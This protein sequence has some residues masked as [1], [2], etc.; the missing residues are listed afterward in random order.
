MKEKTPVHASRALQ[1]GGQTGSALGLPY[2]PAQAAAGPLN[3]RSSHRA[4]LKLTSFM[5]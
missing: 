2:S 4:L 5:N 1:H 3:G